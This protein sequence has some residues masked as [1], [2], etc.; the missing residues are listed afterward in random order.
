MMDQIF[1]FIGWM[2]LV[3]RRREELLSGGGLLKLHIT[4]SFPEVR[5]LVIFLLLKDEMSQYSNKEIQKKK[6]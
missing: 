1:R 4:R 2:L 3:K 5:Y 6:L